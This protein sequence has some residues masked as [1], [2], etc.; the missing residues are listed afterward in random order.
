MAKS[1]TA[2][3]K[4]L[5]TRVDGAKEVIKLLEDMGQNAATVLLQAAEAGGK[6]ALAEARRRCPVRSGRLRS[7]LSLKLGKKTALKA[8]VRVVHGR[9]EYYGTFVELGTKKSP[10]QPFMRPAVDENKKQIADAVTEEI[11]RAI[12]RSR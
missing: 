2:R 11:G 4:K 3:Q 7:S 1:Y 9:K 5:F 12:G 10:A 8:N 6:I